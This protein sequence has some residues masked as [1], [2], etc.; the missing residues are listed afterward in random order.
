[1][2]IVTSAFLDTIGNRQSA[3]SLLG[4]LSNLR[5]LDHVA[6][7]RSLYHD[8]DAGFGISLAQQRFDCEFVR[9]Q[10]VKRR[11]RATLPPAGF[12]WSVARGQRSIAAG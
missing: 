10:T 11:S 9:M 1:M 8:R 7:N 6:V 3:I 5:H 12:R 4:L 2:P